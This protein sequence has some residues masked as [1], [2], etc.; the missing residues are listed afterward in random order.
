ML[1]LTEEEGRR[2]LRVAR[3]AL[4]AELLS[5]PEQPPSGF[6]SSLPYPGG[7]FVTLR[8][9]GRLR[10]CI[11][12]VKILLPLDRTVYECAI[13]AALCD[14]RFPP[15]TS[16]EVTSLQI[17][18]SVL[19][20][21]VEAAPEEI[22]LGRHGLLISQGIMHGLLLPQVAVEWK[23]DRVRFLEETS[24]KAGLCP[25]AWRCGARIELFTAQVFGES[26]LGS[27]RPAGCSRW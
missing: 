18:I 16:D 3:A 27:L 8:K 5:R 15:V 25:D 14:F 24:V 26:K 17:E 22:E 12:R 9:D 11:G 4:E 1:P 21:P 23:W 13:G 10:G 20:P 6:P 7:V 2:L 19:S